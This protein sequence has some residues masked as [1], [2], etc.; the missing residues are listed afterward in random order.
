MI[1]HFFCLS[2]DKIFLMKTVLLSFFL[3]CSTSSFSQIFVENLYDEP[4]FV[5]L[6]YNQKGAAYSGWISQGWFEIAPGEK[7]EI[8]HYNPTGKRIY[9]HAHSSIKDIEGGEQFLVAPS[10]NFRIKNP[11]KEETKAENSEYEW[12]YFY[13]INRR[14]SSSFKNKETIQLIPQ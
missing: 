13:E 2:F 7:K 1:F 6:V 5:V 8:L 10:G 12:R 14:M 4:F 11:E 3:F 9:L